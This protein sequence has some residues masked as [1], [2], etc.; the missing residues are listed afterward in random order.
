MIGSMERDRKV[1]LK[2]AA[3]IRLVMDSVVIAGC[4]LPM[5]VRAWLPGLSQGAGLII[6]EESLGL[7]PGGVAGHPE[8]LAR[9]EANCLVDSARKDR[10]VP[11]NNHALKGI[12]L[13]DIVV[14]HL[15]L[16]ALSLNMP[17]YMVFVY[18]AWLH[19]PFTGRLQR[20]I[21]YIPGPA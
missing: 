9:L 19:L 8:A 17:L 6:A 12:V 3:S 10:M 20:T 7:L 18:P 13:E 1:R 11:K 4:H 5:K 2:E 21:G 14:Y 15:L 16:T